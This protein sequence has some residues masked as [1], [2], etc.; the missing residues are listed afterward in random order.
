MRNQSIA[1]SAPE[2]LC[3]CRKRA[4]E[5]R[6]EADGRDKARITGEEQAF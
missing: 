5:K 3:R 4:V 1:V 2:D 6:E